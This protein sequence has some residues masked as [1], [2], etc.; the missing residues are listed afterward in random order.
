MRSAILKKSD[1]ETKFT[2]K[3]YTQSQGRV[4]DR[5]GRAVGVIRINLPTWI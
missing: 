3:G 5:F 4:Y 2:G 1:F